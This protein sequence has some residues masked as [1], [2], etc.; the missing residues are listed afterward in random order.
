MPILTHCT[1][2]NLYHIEP[3]WSEIST[4]SV[5]YGGQHTCCI[6]AVLEAVLE[7]PWGLQVDTVHGPLKG[8]SL[9][10]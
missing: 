5:M 8:G 1:V 10:S 7:V 3:T 2:R 4:P 9:R 6:V